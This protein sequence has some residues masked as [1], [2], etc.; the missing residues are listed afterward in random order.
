MSVLI[1]GG[2]VVTAADDYVA[3]VFVDGE[4]VT[5]IGE[6]L[7]ARRR[8]DDRRARQV[9]PPGLR[10]PAHPPRHALRRHGH[11]RRRR[12]GPDGGGVRRHDLPR[13]LLHPGQGPDASPTRSTSWHAKA[14]GKQLIDMGY[15]IA[16]TDLSGGGALEE[17]A[18]LP[19]QGVTSYKLF[20]AYKGALMV[21]DETLFRTM[22]VAARDRRARDGARRERR[23]DRRARAG[24]RSPPATPS[25]TGTRSRGRPRP[26]AR[27]PTAPSSS[28]TSP[29]RR[30]TSSTSPARRRSSRS[31]PRARRAGRS[32]ARPA[33]STSSSTTSFLER[34][35]F[36][37][38]KYVYTPPPRDK[39][40]QERALA[41]RAQRRPLGRSRPTTA[42]FN[43]EGQ[44]ALGRDDFSKIPNG[45]PGLENRLQMIHHFGVRDGPDHAQPHGRAARDE[46]GE[47]LRPLP[48]QGDARASA[49]TPTSSSSIPRSASRSRPPTTTRGSTTT[50]TR[51]PRWSARPRS[52]SLRGNVL[53]EDDELVASPGIGR[54]V[55]RARFGEELRPE[56]PS[57]RDRRP[58]GERTPSATGSALA[59]L[60]RQRISPVPPHVR[61]LGEAGSTRR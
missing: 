38:A 14:D 33:P 40:N 11:D 10:R 34:P 17:L 9:R 3:D 45:G 41:R 39:A 27:R 23:R 55:A 18:T 21:D 19:E 42:V 26:R 7:D 32:G 16:V 58:T 37:G 53:V 43:W 61:S 46:P 35:N 4:R 20:M 22:E 1:K 54:F 50:S 6:S 31:P 29:A 13:R 15:H 59:T 25:R 52:C 8:P 47:A 51:G 48:A 44:K 24:R 5:L 30:S 12:V 56:A 28:P 49:P 57:T 60:G 2:R 36:E